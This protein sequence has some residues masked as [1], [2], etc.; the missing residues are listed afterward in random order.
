MRSL[1]LLALLALVAAP[2]W[3]ADGNVPQNTLKSL[4]LSGMQPV[5]DA[6][7]MQVRGANSAF[8][9]VKGT[10]LIAGQLLTPDTKNFV[11]FSSINEVDGNAETVACPLFL[12]LIKDHQVFVNPPVTLNVSFPDGSTYS[13][14]ISGTVGGTGK[15]FVF[16][17]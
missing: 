13:G 7:G 14:I 8:G 3:A 5:S 11:S 10:S 6:E 16:G 15:I 2:V 4:G 1:A 12:K 17:G 9:M